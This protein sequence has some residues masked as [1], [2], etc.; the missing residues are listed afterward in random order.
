MN[1]TPPP[2]EAP[3]PATAPAEPELSLVIPVYNEAGNI[4]P[5]AQG[6]ARMPLAPWNKIS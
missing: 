5:L 4:L 3:L 6:C 1:P 2:R